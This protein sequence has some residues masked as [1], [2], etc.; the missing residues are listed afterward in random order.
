MRTITAPTSTSKD[1]L[2][3]GDVN[4]V[5]FDQVDLTS[6][7]E[8]GGIGDGVSGVGGVGTGSGSGRQQSN[9]PARRKF[10]LPANTRRFSGHPEYYMNMSNQVP[11][12]LAM[13]I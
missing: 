13:K 2:D 7:L 6:L 1:P 11:S 5:S 8:E 3:Y 9:K 10:T 4:L 12:S